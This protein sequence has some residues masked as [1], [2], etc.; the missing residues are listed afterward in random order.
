[1]HPPEFVRKMISE[2]NAEQ[3]IAIIG[4]FMETQRCL[5]TDE[6]RKVYR[7]VHVFLVAVRS[8]LRDLTPGQS[9]SDDEVLSVW[10]QLGYFG[11][12]RS[13]IED[14]LQSVE[15]GI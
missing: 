13:A 10:A 15:E 7:F 2:G 8:Q 9:I 4:Q 6:H 12:E 3:V 14:Y 5:R 11:L 1:M